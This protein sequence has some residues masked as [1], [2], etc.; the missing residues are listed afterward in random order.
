[1]NFWESFKFHK[2]IL[3]I[4]LHYEAIF[5]HDKLAKNANINVSTFFFQKGWGEWCQRLF[6][7]IPKIH[8]SW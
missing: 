7:T 3:Q 4:V 5:D 8:P 2:A 6:E 1:M